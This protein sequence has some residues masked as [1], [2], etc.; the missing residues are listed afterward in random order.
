[1]IRML[2]KD[3][4]ILARLGLLGGTKFGQGKTDSMSSALARPYMRLFREGKEIGKITYVFFQVNQWPSH[5]LGS[6]CYT[7]K[8]R[9]LFYPGLIERKVNW[10]YTKPWFKSIKSSGF[11]DHL[12]LEKGYVKWHVTILEPDGTKRVLLQSYRTRHVDKGV[13]WWFSLSIRGPEL[14]ETT[15]EEHTLTFPSPPKDSSRRVELMM[16][17]RENAIHHLV[18]L[19]SMKLET[20]EFLHFDFFIGREDTTARLINE[21]QLPCY[22]PT[23]KPIADGYAQA[24]G[25]QTHFRA[26]AVSV[27]GMPEKFWVIVSKHRGE[28]RDKAIVRVEGSSWDSKTAK[29]SD[30]I[31]R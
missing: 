11:V 15:P 14:L 19:D 20:G 18:T 8:P 9:V 3:S 30:S 16:K 27:E 17:A 29:Q 26:H 2:W 21:G 25:E 1:M 6:L 12:T 22:A 23:E 28:L 10:S 7:T 5:V 31:R 24:F 13:L 4:R